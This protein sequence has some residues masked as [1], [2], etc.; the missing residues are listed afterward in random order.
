[1]KKDTTYGNFYYNTS[2]ISAQIY[3]AAGWYSQVSITIKMIR[4]ISASFLFSQKVFFLPTQF[5]KKFRI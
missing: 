2:S 4:V 1:M 3:R 5:K